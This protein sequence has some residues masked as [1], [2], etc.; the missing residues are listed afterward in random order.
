MKDTFKNLESGIT[1]AF[2]ELAKHLPMNTALQLDGLRERIIEVCNKTHQ[3][4]MKEAI[5]KAYDLGYQK[6]KKE[7]RELTEESRKFQLNRGDEESG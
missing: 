7:E 5:K 1:S 2:T 4:A 3:Q 6:A